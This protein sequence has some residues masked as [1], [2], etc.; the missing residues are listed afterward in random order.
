MVVRARRV[1]GRRR[2]AT[3]PSAGSPP[4]AG[5][6]VALVV[7][8]IALFAVVF[9]SVLL[10]VFRAGLR[11][12]WSSVARLTPA[13]V[14]SRRIERPLAGLICADENASRSSARER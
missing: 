8:V 10:R 11:V 1:A 7:R 4:V 5:S 3:A 12:G 14:S 9:T 2:V 6:A 13:S